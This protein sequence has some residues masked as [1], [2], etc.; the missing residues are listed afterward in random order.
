VRHYIRLIGFDPDSS[1][2]LERL[3]DVHREATVYLTDT[4]HYA[5]PPEVE[6]PARMCDLFLAT[7]AGSSEVRRF[8]CMT[9]KIMHIIHHLSG[10]ELTF[11]TPV[12]EADLFNRLSSKMFVTIDRMRE[13]GIALQEFAAGKKSRHSLITKLVTKRSTLASHIFDRQRFRIVVETPE[14]VLRALLYLLRHVVPFNY[15]IPEQSQNGIITLD[16]IAKELDIPVQRVLER[17][18]ESKVAELLP[19]AINPSPP[20]EFSG[21]NYRDVNF[22]ADIPVRIDDIAPLA[23]PAITFVQTEFQLV[24]AKTAQSNEEGENAHDRYKARQMVRVK[25]RLEGIPS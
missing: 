21:H 18:P 11:S 7:S 24:D 10:R 17:W 15:I 2:D 20:N 16:S 14:D 13:H 12:S 23:S 3:R 9:L 6:Y 22:V 1:L 19:S 8:S 4:L 5:L 25:D